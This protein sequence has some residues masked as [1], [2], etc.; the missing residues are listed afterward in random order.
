L[1][2]QT[3]LVVTAMPGLISKAYELA[4]FALDG[5]SKVALQ[6]VSGRLYGN[7]SSFG[8][9]RDLSKAFQAPN[10]NLQIVVRPLQRDDDLA[11]LREGG[12]EGSMARFAQLRMVEA[13][14]PTCYVAVAPNGDIC[15]MQWLIP[16]TE[17]ERIQA[18]FGSQFPLLNADEAL[19]E[20]AYTAPAYRGRRIMGC[21]MAQIAEKAQQLGARWVVTFVARG[22]EPSIK[23]CERAGFEPYILRHE[24]WRMLHRSITFAPISQP[25]NSQVS[26]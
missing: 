14:L 20:G 17:N 21:A 25:G 26:V 3:R 5:H 13:N 15:Y 18:N 2:Q 4:R 6:A 24:A 16:A 12:Q 19:L 7:S 9:R 8:F 23:G 11:F 22:N 1:S 10:A